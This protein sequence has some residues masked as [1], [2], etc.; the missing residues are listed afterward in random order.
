MRWIYT[1]LIFLYGH[2][3]SCKQTL[4]NYRIASDDHRVDRQKGRILPRI[5]IVQQRY[6]ILKKAE[7]SC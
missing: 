4:I 7:R 2:G 1:N 6:Y 3:L 5:V